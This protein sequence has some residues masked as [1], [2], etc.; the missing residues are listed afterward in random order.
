MNNIY[1]NELME[2]AG[3]HHKL[4]HKKIYE[5]EF[6]GR[7]CGYKNFKDFYEKVLEDE[8]RQ[9]EK[10]NDPNREVSEERRKEIRDL[11]LNETTIKKDGLVFTVY[12]YKMKHTDYPDLDEILTATKKLRSYMIYTT[13]VIVECE[14]PQGEGVMTGKV[15]GL[16]GYSSKKQDEAEQ[17]YKET[18]DL[19]NN[20]TIEELMIKIRDD[21]KENKI[22]MEK[23]FNEEL[24]K[25]QRRKEKFEKEMIEIRKQREQEKAERK[26][27]REQEKLKK[28]QNKAEEMK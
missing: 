1:M 9:Q 7:R 25:K 24:E 3:N 8:R 18:C 4:L 28:E 14:E 20:S 15:E 27:K 13:S 5:I 19:I 22:K 17:K 2:L 10:Y 6:K 23:H 16:F 12:T 21:F 11:I 26:A